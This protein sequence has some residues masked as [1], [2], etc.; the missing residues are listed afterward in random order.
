MSIDRGIDAPGTGSSGGLEGGLSRENLTR[1]VEQGEVRTVILAMPDLEGRLLGKRLTAQHF[2]G[3]VAE[4]GAEGCQYMLASDVEM[5]LIEE[6]TLVGWSTGFGDMVLRPDFSSA[7][8]LPWEPGSVLILAD[9][10]HLDSSGPVSAAPRQIL[11]KQLERLRELGLKANASTELEFM[12]FD[13]SYREAWE[14]RYRDMRPAPPYNSDYAIFD[15][16]GVETLVGRIRSE[17]QEAGMVVEGSKGECNFGQHEINFRYGEALQIADDHIVYKLGAK[18]IARQSGKSLTFMAK[19]DERAGNSC[20]IHLSLFES[21]GANAFAKNQRLL[22]MFVAGQLACLREMT[23]LLAPQ[24]NSY[25]RFVA[26]S[27]APTRVA[28]GHDNRTCAVRVL[29]HGEGLRFEHRLP[30]A[31]VNPHLAI[32]GVVAA[33]IYGIQNELELEPPVQGDA[34]ATEKERVPDSLMAACEVF[35]G[36]KVAREALGDEVVDHLVARGEAESMA[37]QGVVSEWERIRGFERL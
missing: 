32:A 21:T 27:F 7:R 30:G 25:K 14:S 37:A 5:E 11:R 12:V 26:R 23:L 29:G 33:G 16:G 20:H 34:D 17:M 35:S 3:H 1:L 4:E 24:V 36:S 18:E 6:N 19:Y 22:D 8:Q 28:W 15:G 10:Q 9:A 31:D 13:T 2:L